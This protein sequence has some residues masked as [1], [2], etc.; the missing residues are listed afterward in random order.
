MKNVFLYYLALIALSAC[1]ISCKDNQGEFLPGPADPRIAGSWQLLERRFIKDSTY[2]VRV[3]TITTTRDTSFYTV[4][5]YTPI[6][7][8]TLTFSPDGRLSASGSEMTY[9]YPI[10]YFRVDS[11]SLDGLLVTFFISTNR[12]SVPFREKV[13]FRKDTLV[14]L[15]RFVEGVVDEG[16]YLKFLRA[17]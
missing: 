5:R 4:N 16:Y 1:I 3:D 7:R 12:A 11:T 8:Q 9:Y 13:E 6:N 15:P 2:S 17:R 10:K 14:L